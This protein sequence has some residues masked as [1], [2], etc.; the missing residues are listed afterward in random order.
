M[1]TARRP[2]YAGADWVADAY[3]VELS[4]IGR[5]AADILGDV[6]AGIYHL[7]DRALRKV[8]WADERF[9]TVDLACQL[10]TWDFC[11]LTLLAILCHDACV[12]L[13][14]EGRPGP[15]PALRLMFHPRQGRTGSLMARHPTIDEAIAAVR[16]SQDTGLYRTPSPEEVPHG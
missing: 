10:A 12:R 14:V 9:I 8:D 2:G 11:H 16:A 1:D 5:K 7:G 4:P 3:K 6:F 13:Q 15:R